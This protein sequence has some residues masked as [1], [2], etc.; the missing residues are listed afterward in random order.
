MS[1]M[2]IFILFFFFFFFGIFR[3]LKLD[4]GKSRKIVKFLADALSFMH[5]PQTNTLEINISSSVH[6]I[7]KKCKKMTKVTIS[8]HFWTLETGLGNMKKLKFSDF[9]SIENFLKRTN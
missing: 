1:K 3:V 8:S 6:K 5:F 2:T 7:F 4:Y 9:S